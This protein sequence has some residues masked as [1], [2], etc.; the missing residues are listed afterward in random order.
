MGKRTPTILDP[1]ATGGDVAEGGFDFQKHLTLIRIP[2]WLKCDGFSEMILEAFGDTEA[3]FFMPEIGISREFIE[4][5]NHDLAPSTFWKE[6]KRFHEMEEEHPGV[7]WRFILVCTGVS[8]KLNPIINA[9]DR[10]R[11]TFTFYEDVPTVQDSSYGMFVER[12]KKFGK[13]EQLA[14]FIFKKVFID[15]DPQKSVQQSF[16]DFREALE[17][18]FPIFS[19][20]NKKYAQAAWDSLSGLLSNRAKPIKRAELETAIWSALPEDHHPKPS[21]INL[22]VASEPI[23]GGW[24]L[25]KKL[26]FNWSDFS[27][28]EMR[29]F[30]S[31]EMWDQIVISQLLSTR[32]WIIQSGRQHQIALTGQKRL[33]ASIAIGAIFS[34]VMGFSINVLEREEKW[35]TD[36][37]PTSNTPNYIWQ[38][39]Y[40]KKEK[41]SELAIALGICRNPVGDVRAYLQGKDFPLLALYGEDALISAKHT[42]QA[43]RKAKE[44][45]SETMTKIGAKTIHLFIAAPSQFSLFLGHRLN[46]TG[47]MQCYER[48]GPN[49]YVPT[50]LINSC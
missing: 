47:L 4:Y 35:S 9:L 20:L 5:K 45:I 36:D 2:T 25:P 34:A 31:T 8:S 23:T 39:E 3:Q 46:A 26:C 12:I 14:R 33:S 6:I 50:C 48:T 42:N 19:N 22:H 27:G 24:E 18:H 29:T 43:V 15:T 30:P 17:T 32:E 44:I 11:G 7:Y 41:A 40:P 49:V 28:K 13:D 10:V 1:E 37:H 38:V 21:L 16:N